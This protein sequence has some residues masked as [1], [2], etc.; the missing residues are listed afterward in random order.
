KL[1]AGRNRYFLEAKFDQNENVNP[2]NTIGAILN[3]LC[4]LFAE[5]ATPSQLISVAETL[6]TAIGS[7]AGLLDGVVPSLAK[8]TRCLVDGTS[9]ECVDVAASMQFLFGKLLEVLSDHKGVA[10]FLDDLQ[11]ADPA[12]L[13]LITSMI[14]KTKGKGSVF[15]ACCFRDDDM[16]EGDPLTVWL[17]NINAFPFQTLHLENMS[18][19]GVN[20]LVSETLRLFPRVTRPLAFILHHKTRGNPLFLRQLF[21]SLKDQGCISL[22]VS[23]LL[24]TWD[25]DEMINL[26]ISDN[27]LSLMM[28]EMQRLPSEVQL[29]LRVASCLGSP[30]KYSIF[31][32]LSKDLGVNLRAF[33]DQATQ[34][35]FLV[36]VDE[37]CIRFSHDKIQQAAYD[38][39]AIQDRLDNHMRFGLAICSHVLDRAGDSDELFFAA[40]NQINR[41]GAD[42]LPDSKQKVMVATWNLKAGRRSIELSDYSTALKLFEHGISFLDQEERWVDQYN[43]SLDL[44]DAAAEMACALNNGAA[45]GKLSQEVGVHAKCDDDRLNCLYAVSKALLMSFKFVDAKKVAFRMLEQFGERVPRPSDDV[46]LVKDM[47]DMKAVLQRMSNDTIMDLKETTPTRKD[48]LLLKLYHDLYVVLHGVDPTRLADPSDG[49]NHLVEWSKLHVAPCIAQFSDMLVATGDAALGYRISSLAL[50]LLDRIG[51]KRYTSAVFSMVKATASWVAEPLQ[52]ISESFLIGYNHGQ[53]S[54]DLKSASINYWFYLENSYPSGQNLSFVREKSRTFALELLQRK[55]QFVLYGT[56]A[57]YLQAS[58][59]VEGL[60]FEEQEVPGLPSSWD[61]LLKSNATKSIMMQRMM[62]SSHQYTRAFLFEQ[63]DK[64][65]EEG[66]LDCILE[67]NGNLRPALFCGVLFEALVS[68]CLMRQTDQDKYR[69][70]GE[71]ALAF[72]RKWSKCNEWN[73]E[74]KR[75]LLEAEMM[76]SCGQHEQASQFY[77]LSIISARKHKFVQ[78]EAVACEV[79]AKFYY[80]R[81]LHQKAHRLYAHS[82]LCYKKWGASAIVSR[83]EHDLQGKFGSAVTQS[84]STDDL[85]ETI[86]TPEEGSSKRRPE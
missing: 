48:V 26:E 12:S 42:T 83:V 29:G 74:N 72:M 31:D 51:A 40:V 58:A 50:R 85:L 59:F 63:Y 62:Y 28:K 56:W 21:E 79:A 5:D 61:N 23:P 16:K 64:L 8:L 15:F 30:V 41:G 19:E 71:A 46:G 60:G 86:L 3:T 53:R 43:L 82:I 2:L 73:F 75:L 35:G 22:S 18:E 65:P 20:E 44:F 70:K 57:L 7:Q 9:I 67:G 4:D 1:A 39:M 38:M 36:E 49:S 45:V 14:S 25:M 32:I 80:D 81:E 76:H 78:E 54:G 55:Q 52:S 24:W 17:T 34:K 77:Q 66:V 13:L 37:T 68:F 6:E 69:R 84:W 10:L 33:L 27:V 47:E 11:W